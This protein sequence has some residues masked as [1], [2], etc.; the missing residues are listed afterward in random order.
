MKSDC[1]GT[2]TTNLHC[3]LADGLGRSLNKH[4]HQFVRLAKALIAAHHGATDLSRAV[5]SIIS[6]GAL[7]QQVHQGRTRLP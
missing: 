7:A 5:E 4:L 3:R 2:Y 1:E 6:R